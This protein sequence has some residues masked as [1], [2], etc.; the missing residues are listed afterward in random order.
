MWLK[1]QVDAYKKKKHN[2][3]T[4]QKGSNKKWTKVG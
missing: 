1:E 4:L 2:K 3:K